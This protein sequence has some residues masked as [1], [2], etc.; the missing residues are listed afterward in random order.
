M[1]PERIA[2]VIAACRAD[3]IALQEVDVGRSRSGG[4]DQAEEIARLLKMVHH[5]HPAL[6]LL[7]E[8][9]GDA[10]LTPHPSRLVK[11]DALPGYARRPTLEPRGALWVEIAVGDGSVQVVNTHFGLSGPERLAQAEALLG[12][13]WLGA[14]HCRGPVV[15][16]GDFNA[17]PWSCAY[18]RLGRRLTDAG[19]L[20]PKRPGP[21]FPSR[22]PILRLDHVFVGEGI[23][24]ERVEA[25]RM[26]LA[27]VAS[28]HLPLLA[29]IRVNAAACQE[30]EG[31]SSS[32][33]SSRALRM[34]SARSQGC[35]ASSVP[36]GSPS[37]SASTSQATGP[38]GEATS[39]QSRAGETISGSSSTA[40]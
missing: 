2:E 31:G 28:D 38:C 5:F 7:E 15:L 40:R 25:V 14:P 3:V 21:T 12:P 9:Y 35:Q 22:F 6:H 29:E 39:G 24:V 13:D 8:R 16:L 32:E 10:I 34:A 23:S 4:L 11:A 36:T 19:R 20:A 37:R 27:R 18:R 17:T 1:S 30:V 26:P 33:G